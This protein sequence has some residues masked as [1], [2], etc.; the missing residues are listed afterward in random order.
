MLNFEKLIEFDG[1]A[2]TVPIAINPANV[3]SISPVKRHLKEVN[4][5]KVENLSLVEI[6]YSLG[7]EVKKV[8]V[9]GEYNRLINKIQNKRNI[10]H[11]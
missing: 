1:R 6:H 8:F 3:I 10:L 7:S 11:G 4:G 5:Q 9:V 2:S